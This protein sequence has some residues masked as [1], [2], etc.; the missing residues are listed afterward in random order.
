[1][2][3]SRLRAFVSSTAGVLIRLGGG[4]ARLVAQHPT[5]APAGSDRAPPAGTM[6]P[7]TASQDTPERPPR[8]TPGGERLTQEL[9]RPHRPRVQITYDVEVAGAIVRKELPFVIGVLADLSLEHPARPL[10]PLRDRK[11]VQIDRDNFNE[12]LG[13]INPRL[14]FQVP[15]RLMEPGLSTPE[16]HL[17]PAL[18]TLD[19]AL[20]FGSRDHF[21]PEAVAR[22]VDP[23]EKL[24]ERRRDLAQQVFRLQNNQAGL[25]DQGPPDAPDQEKLVDRI[26]RIDHSLSLQL[27]EILHH[28]D[29]QKLEGTWRGL[30]YLVTNTETSATL[31]I[32]VL[33]VSKHELALDLNTAI[34]LDQ[35]QIFQ[36]VYEGEYRVSGGEPYGVLIGDYEFTNGPE[37]IDLLAKLSQA[38]ATAF[39]P[40]ISAV[41]PRF[42]GFDGWQDLSRPCDLERTVTGLEYIQWRSFRESEDSRFVVL[43]MPRVL[44]RLPYGATSHPIEAFGFEEVD[45]GK[46]VP[47]DHF[48]WMNPA[49]V[50]GTRLTEAFARYGLCVAIRGAQGGGKVEGLPAFIFTSDDSCMDL[51]CPTETYITDRREAELSKLGFLPLCHYKNTDY[52]VFFGGQ[53]AHKPKRYD[54]PDATAN[55]AIASR[56][57][58]IMVTSRFAHYLKV[59]ARDMIMSFRYPGEI[60]DDLNRWIQGYAN[61]EPN[62]AGG[63][64]PLREAHVEADVIPGQPG[65]YQIKAWMRPWLPMEEL[66]AALRLVIPIPRAGGW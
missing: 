44:A 39:A 3:S 61:P 2:W 7:A 15:N 52:A 21:G 20:S 10:K 59:M 4:F 28:P 64:F 62:G 58:F 27:A 50:F 55:A 16:A 11:F 57:P 37:D 23:L 29:F 33:D 66:T 53:T 46:P 30:D 19:V 51:R 8:P 6:E 18:D 31:R 49:Y 47:H 42:F 17:V 13:V 9:K 32:K 34:E 63:Q 26:S 60:G 48:T 24:L 38:A 41:S 56:L 40:L 12:I 14:T 1:M 65:A 25:S 43:T 54:R 5:K 35:S 22:Q 36:K 45:A